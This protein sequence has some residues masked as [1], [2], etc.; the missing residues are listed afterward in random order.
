MSRR[1]RTGSAESPDDAQNQGAEERHE[2]P[3]KSQRKREVESIT[4][5]GEELAGLKPRA[6]A[7][8][9]LDEDLLIAIRAS[10]TLT[11]GSRNR[12]IK[13]IG[14]LLRSR[15]HEA[16]REALAGIR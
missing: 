5:L 15:D 10:A 4:K 11:R 13:L 2:P 1:A 12:Q 9:D 6:L 7:R 3:S 16:I 8:L 14:K